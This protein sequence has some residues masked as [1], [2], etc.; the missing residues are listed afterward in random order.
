MSYVFA[1][2]G[3]QHGHISRF[4]TE[5]LQMGHS[6]A[7]IHDSGDTALARRLAS[8]FNIP[9][10]EDVEALLVPSVDIIGSSAINS[11]K[12]NIIELCEQHGKPV[13]VD[14]PAVTSRAGLSRLEA[15]VQRGRIQVGMMLTERYRPSVN[16]LKR[17]LDEGMFGDITS[18]AI[19]RPLK[20]FPGARAP[21]FFSKEQNGG[22]LVD[23]MIHD[24][25][26]LRWLSGEEICDM[27]SLAGKH[28]VPESVDFYDTA[29]VQLVLGEGIIASLHADWLAPEQGWAADGR[30]FVTGT[31]GCAEI[32]L[33]GD[34]AIAEEELLFT[35]SEGQRYQQEELVPSQSGLS[36]DFIRRIEGRPAL[37]TQQDILE[38]CKAV[39]AADENAH[40]W[41]AKWKG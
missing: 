2:I 20:L 19:R 35:V 31:M 11:E 30:I 41:K 16:T 15:V 5:M 24:F 18:I 13:M 25:D 33:A 4:I 28:V 14:K 10:V 23:L 26:L 29:H 34:P 21:W 22:I 38:A 37:L 32:R 36:E 39:I 40:R 9:Y 3:C 6:C 17:R 7:G 1:I 12:I 8:D 27:H